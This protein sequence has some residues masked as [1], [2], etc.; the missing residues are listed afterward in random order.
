MVIRGAYLPSA[1]CEFGISQYYSAMEKQTAANP[2]ELTSYVRELLGSLRLP[3]IEYPARG[4][5]GKMRGVE[6]Y[7]DKFPQI[8]FECLQRYH[9]YIG[10]FPEHPLQCKTLYEKL[11]WAKLVVPLSIPTPADKLGVGNF[12][13]KQLRGDVR[14]AKVYWISD[15]PNFP[16]QSKVPMVL[17]I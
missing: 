12:I 10:R 14:T 15:R 4:K 13:P 16:L 9:R 8:L 2:V 3:P 1:Y 7:H 5:Q 17:T 6:F 11:F